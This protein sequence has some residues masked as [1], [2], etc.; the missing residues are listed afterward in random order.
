MQKNKIRNGPRIK[1][2]VCDLDNTLYDWVAYFVP[3]FYAMVDEVVKISGC[4]REQLLDDFRE[5][6]VKH[7]DS[8]HPFALLETRTIQ[9]RYQ[10]LS[11][12]ELA[13][14][15]DP[16]FHAFNSRRKVCLKPY[17]GVHETLDVLSTSGVKLV[18]H[19]ESKLYGALDRLNRLD[20]LKHFSKIYCRER[21]HSMHPDPERANSFWDRLSNH[22]IHELPLS[23]RKP[24]P[25]LLLDI[26]KDE[27]VEPI[28]VAYLGD[29]MSHDMLMAKSAGITSIWAKYGTSHNLDDYAK[30]VRISHWDKQDIIREAE[31]KKQSVDIKVDAILENG[32]GEMIGLLG[33][34]K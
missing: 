6:H 16:A 19:T 33:I 4:D 26:C 8:E 12:K 1:L 9:N 32:I 25:K 22:T 29:S 23:E 3:S 14:V 31:L 11:R 27:G 24:N 18:A 10:N 21:A 17:L 34:K 28:E 7:H 20:L 2:L 15:M 30:L 5:V 13:R